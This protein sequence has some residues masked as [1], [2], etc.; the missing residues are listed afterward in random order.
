MIPPFNTNSKYEMFSVT[1]TSVVTG[2]D[3]AEAMLS[4]RVFACKIKDNRFIGSEN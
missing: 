1:L 2:L 3:A 4:V